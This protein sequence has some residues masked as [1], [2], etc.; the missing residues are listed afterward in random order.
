MESVWTLK[1]T[2]NDLLLYKFQSILA[3]IISYLHNRPLMDPENAWNSLLRLL[4]KL[5]AAI[6]P[7]TDESAQIWTTKVQ[8]LLHW[9]QIF[10]DEVMIYLFL[11]RMHDVHQVIKAA[12]V[13]YI[14]IATREH[15]R[16]RASVQVVFYWPA[17]ASD[18]CAGNRNLQGQGRWMRD[19][20]PQIQK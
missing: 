10:I 1:R 3:E 11:E 20:W 16:A 4:V 8:I 14:F 19:W 6:R 17:P 7:Q 5:K 2:E 18:A 15:K 12:V 13:G 9:D